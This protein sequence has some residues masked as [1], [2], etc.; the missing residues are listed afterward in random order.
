[1]WFDSTP[2]GLHSWA[3]TAGIAVVVFLVIEAAK[4]VIRSVG[5]RPDATE[6]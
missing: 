6:G 5:D 4:A 3:L 1:V 2:I